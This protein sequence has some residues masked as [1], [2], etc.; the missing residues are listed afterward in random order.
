MKPSFCASILE[1]KIRRGYLELC[2]TISQKLS[3]FKKGGDIICDVCRKSPCD[4]RCPNAPKPPVIHECVLCGAEIREG[5]YYYKLDGIPHCEEC[6]ENGR[7][8]AESSWS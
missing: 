3:K 2:D 7:E 8:E 6:V 1:T 4:S 5:D